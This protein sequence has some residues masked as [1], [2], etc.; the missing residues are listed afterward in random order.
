[1]KSEPFGPS[2]ISKYFMAFILL[3]MF[4]LRTNLTQVP[5]TYL[6]N[7]SCLL[8]ENYF[9]KYFCF[10]FI[11]GN[12]KLLRSSSVP[13]TLTLKEGA[14]VVLIKNLAGGL[15]NGRRGTVYK[16]KRGKCPIFYFGAIFLN[17]AQ[18][19]LTFTMQNFSLSLTNTCDAKLCN[20]CASL[21]GPDL[22]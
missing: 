3:L 8:S 9:F 15:F 6:T 11:S 21:P 7:M 10:P 4:F 17:Y 1:M 19:L 13:K 18:R 5:V 20:D 12:T 16:L 2:Y 14:P 22:R